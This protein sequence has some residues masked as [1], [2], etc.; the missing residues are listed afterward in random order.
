MCVCVCVCVSQLRTVFRG[1]TVDKAEEEDYG[2]YSREIVDEFVLTRVH[3]CHEVI[4]VSVARNMAVTNSHVMLPT[5]DV[6]G[7]VV[8]GVSAVCLLL[9]LVTWVTLRLTDRLV[10]RR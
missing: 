7:S 6:I 5:D 9:A 3:F 10:T 2:M 1:C 8:H 4:S